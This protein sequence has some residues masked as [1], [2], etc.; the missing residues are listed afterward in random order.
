MT[1][2]LLTLFLAFCAT[3]AFSQDRSGWGSYGGDA[4]GSRFSTNKQINVTNVAKLKSAWTFR[5]GELLQ[6]EGNDAREDAAFEATPILANNTL[7]FTT[8]SCRVFAI[9]ASSGAQKWS[10]DP[11]VNLKNDFS[12]I[13]SRGVSAWPAAG[14]K[15]NGPAAK[16]IFIATLDGRLIALD[17]GTGEPVVYFGKDG[18]VD[19][20]AGFGKEKIL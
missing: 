14:D 5:T 3:S 15:A 10:F 9:D 17:A 2:K 20:R 4:G 1:Y 12:E 19:L 7:Y 6:Y 13:T 8:A 18:T 11:E 16:K